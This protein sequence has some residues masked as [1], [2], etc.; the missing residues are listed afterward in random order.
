[1][2]SEN[3]KHHNG[4]LVSNNNLMWVGVGVGAAA[5]GIALALSRRKRDRWDAARQVT[6]R[7]ANHTSDLA[8]AGKDI[9][10][11]VRIIFG[12]SRKVVEEATELW[13]QGRK[14]AGI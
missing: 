7:V 14:L 13:S 11:R 8:E 12:E 4:S 9:L 2:T 6:R 5:L 10:G 3:G 1:M